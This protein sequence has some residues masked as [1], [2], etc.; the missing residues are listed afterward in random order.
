MRNR[1]T[2]AVVSLAAAGALS[3]AFI[4]PRAEAA[5]PPA[6]VS[7]SYLGKGSSKNNVIV[8][9]EPGRGGFAVG[10]F[11]SQEGNDLFLTLII[12]PPGEEPQ[13]WE[14]YG[15]V[16]N[17]NFWAEGDVGDGERVVVSGTAKGAPGK[18][19]LKGDGVFLAPTHV[20]DLKFNVKQS[21][22]VE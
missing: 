21:Q 7:G 16:G 1:I 13:F 9:E 4:Q 15:R 22:L 12:S 5:V 11:A 18:I 10:A 20:S 17:G 19:A 2:L 6:D 8:D 3:A 14:L